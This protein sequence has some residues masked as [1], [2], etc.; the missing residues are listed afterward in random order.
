[1]LTRNRP[2]EP[3]AQPSGLRPA[4]SLPRPNCLLRPS[5][6]IYPR[7]PIPFIFKLLRT[8]LHSPKSQLFYFQAIPHSWYKTPGGG[9]GSTAWSKADP[10]AS[11]GMTEEIKTSGPGRG[12]TLPL[13]LKWFGLELVSE[14]GP[15][16]GALMLPPRRSR[17]LS[18]AESL[19]NPQAVPETHRKEVLLC[20]P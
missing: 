4:A 13:R 10:S 1:L 17:I 3:L 16:R 7:S 18:N 20:P 15:A 2:L 14:R 9:G 19:R 12:V 5:R 8:L 6:V 11:L